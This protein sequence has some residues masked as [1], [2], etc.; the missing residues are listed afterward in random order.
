MQNMIRSAV[1]LD[2]VAHRC[3][4]SPSLFNIYVIVMTEAVEAEKQGVTVG[5]DT[6]SVLVFADY[7][8]GISETTRRNKSSRHYNILENGERQRT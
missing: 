7:F 3:A 6:L 5:E 1:M 4:L 2:G 8:V